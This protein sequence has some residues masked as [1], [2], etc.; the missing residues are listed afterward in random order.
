MKIGILTHYNVYNQGAQLQLSAMAHWLE[1]HGH[2]PVVLTYE[3]NFDFWQ[4]EREKNSASIRA[5]PYYLRHYL[6]EKGLGLTLFNVRKVLAH[7][8]SWKAY[9]FAP[10]DQSGCDAVIIGSDEVFSIDVGC[11]RMM[12]GHDLGVPAVAYAPSFGRTTMETLAE[13]DCTEIA[14]S[15]LKTLKSLSA[16]DAHT[17]AMLRELTGRE[18]PLV[19]DPVLLYQGNALGKRTATEKRPYLLVYGYDRNF[20]DPGEIAAIWGYAKRHN[21][22]TLSVG[23]YHGWCDRNVPC[24]AGQWYTW[25]RDAACVV[26][27]T[28]HGS[29]VAMKNHC[30]TAIFIREG[31]NTFKL[32]SLLEQT[33][34]ENRELSAVTEEELERVLSQPGDYQAVDARIRELVAQSEAYLCAALEEIHGECQLSK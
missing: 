5:L 12:Y 33:G 25:F 19:C 15:G 27:D 22:K 29:V 21:L 30:N 1:E 24:D 4:G 17:Q 20:T 14:A 32:R 7:Q 13:Y 28:F 3:K 9:T 16:R 34:M 26:T 18:V 10:Y 6:L 23:T 2:T 11:N 31:L 8:Q